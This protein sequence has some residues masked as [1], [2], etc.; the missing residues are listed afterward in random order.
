MPNARALHGNPYDGHAHGPVVAGLERLTDVEARRIHVDKGYRGHGYPKKVRVW[1]SGQ[2]RRVTKPIRRK[3]KYR[4]AVAPV[5]GHVKAE[6]HME[7]N[8]LI[9]RA[10]DRATAIMAAAGDNLSPLIRW[11]ETLI[12]HPD[13]HAPQG[14]RRRSDRLNIAQREFFTVE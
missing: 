12:S 1:I 10:G 6:H 4:A 5:I 8:H 3:M 13:R 14:S 11:I 9:G 7:R 2:L